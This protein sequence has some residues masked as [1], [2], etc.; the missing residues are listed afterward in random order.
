[1]N[2]C[3]ALRKFAVGLVFSCLLVSP[4]FGFALLGPYEDWMQV[5]NSFRLSQMF[6]EAD[7]N[8]GEITYIP[9]DIGGPMPIGSEYR[10]NVPVI[11]YAFDQSFVDYFGAEGMREVEAAF[12][13]LNQLPAA[14]QINPTNYPTDVVRPNYPAMTVGLYDLKST[15]LS[16]LLEQLGLAQPTRN[17]V[18]VR[19]MNSLFEGYYPA[20]AQLDPFL[21]DYFYRRNFD[22]DSYSSS[23][24][25]NGALHEFVFL[26][27]VWLGSQIGD[28]VEISIDHLPVRHLAVADG[29]PEAGYYFT[30]L[31]RDDIGGLRYLL[32]FTNI[33]FETPL[34][35]VHRLEAF[36][37]RNG[38][39]ER[40]LT[41][42]WYPGVEKINFVRHPYL[43]RQNRSLVL[44]RRY[45][46]YFY[47]NGALQGARVERD[48]S[49][50]D[51]LFTVDNGEETPANHRFIYPV[52]RTG[53]TN[54]INNA[55]ANGNADGPGPGTIVPQIHFAFRRLGNQL[56]TY[57]GESGAYQLR[58]AWASYTSNSSIITYPSQRFLKKH[59]GDMVVRQTHWDLTNNSW[60]FS[61]AQFW[62]L[63]VPIGGL[64]LLQNSTDQTNWIT[65]LTVTNAGGVIEWSC[66]S[67]NSAEIFRV[68]PK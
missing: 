65:Q 19:R 16:L 27:P 31:S 24:F 67:S 51:I 34:T 6:P 52:T 29:L 37:I 12:K 18:V 59:A 28:A 7:V 25:V 58:K 55:V 48:I 61:Q 53:T 45:T 23:F 44:R 32:N 35:D 10:W 66:Y 43:P 41:A 4:C 17:I 22:L 38:G 42:T 26:W 57:L 39:S 2:A 11:S 54:W 60:T 1:M 3:Q 47:E 46:D 62:K 5:S 64:A 14:S 49:R 33:N 9:G 15:T 21:D 8:D 63:P 13:M 36:R 68:I 20:S 56:V 30:G 40:D 50:P